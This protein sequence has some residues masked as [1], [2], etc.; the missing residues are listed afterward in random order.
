[1]TVTGSAASNPSRPED[2]DR[3]ACELAEV[4][5]KKK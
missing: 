2:L 3:G 5:V 1:M 4:P